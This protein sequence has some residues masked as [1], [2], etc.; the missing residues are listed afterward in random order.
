MF[1]AV[2]GGSAMDDDNSATQIAL[3]RRLIA[4]RLAP[5]EVRAVA[6]Q[7]LAVLESKAGKPSVHVPLASPTRSLLNTVPRRS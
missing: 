2:L 7:L 3:Y 6:A 4:L 1:R 5:A